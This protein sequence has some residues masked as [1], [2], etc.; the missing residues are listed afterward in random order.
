MLVEKNVFVR[1]LVFPDEGSFTR[2]VRSNVILF[3]SGTF[4]LF[5]ITS[6]IRR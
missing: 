2:N 4:D 3:V 6:N 5:V 1:S